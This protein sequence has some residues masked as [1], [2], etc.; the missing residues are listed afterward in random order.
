MAGYRR[1]RGGVD[2]GDLGLAVR[3]HGIADVVRRRRPRR[4]RGR[5]AGTARHQPR[6]FSAWETLRRAPVDPRAGGGWRGCRRGSRPGRARIDPK[7]S[8]PGGRL[9][10]RGGSATCGGGGGRL[11][12]GQPVDV[13]GSAGPGL[14]CS[15][16]P[17]DIRGRQICAGMAS[18]RTEADVG[19]A[20]YVRT[21]E[22]VGASWSGPDP[23]RGPAGR[24]TGRQSGGGP[25]AAQCGQ[26]PRYCA[27]L[28]KGSRGNGFRDRTQPGDVQCARGGRLGQCHR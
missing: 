26:D 4:Y 15:R 21:A 1:D 23:E 25:D 27:V 9:D 3:R 28:P 16:L 2:R 6:S 18:D 8:G 7:R 24:R 11:V 13:L 17:G 12:A 22:R 5:D 10:H 14:R 20:E 19:A